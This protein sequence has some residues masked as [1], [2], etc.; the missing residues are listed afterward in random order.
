[1]NIK[2]LENVYA[3]IEKIKGAVK[4]K[5]ATGKQDAFHSQ[6][7]AKIALDTPVE[8][9]I[10]DCKIKGFNPQQVLPLLKQL[11]LKFIINELDKLK[12]YLGVNLA[13]NQAVDLSNNSEPEEQQLSL[14]TANESGITPNQDIIQINKPQVT[15]QPQIITTEEQLEELISIL[16]NHTS[17]DKPV[18]WDT[19]TTSLEPHNAE[20]VGI[21]CCWGNEL[22]SIA[23]IPTGHTDWQTNR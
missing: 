15:I 4:N 16:K 11:E 5:L 9:T 21:G 13:E 22:T 1:M 3:N 12:E 23:Y 10:K 6:F 7:L 20:L 19:E 17:L 14:F 2:T 8:I 18:A